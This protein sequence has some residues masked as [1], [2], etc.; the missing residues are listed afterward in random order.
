LVKNKE[1][2]LEK[3]IDFCCLDWDSEILKFEKKKMPVSTAS[4]FQAN[5]PIYDKSINLNLKYT[6]FSDF[7]NTLEK[8]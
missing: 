8:L 6:Q 3:V 7:F 5:Q 1:I 4:I 2:E